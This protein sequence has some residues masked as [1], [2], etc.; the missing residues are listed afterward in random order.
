MRNPKTNN[1]SD[2]ARRLGRASAVQVYP[3]CRGHTVVGP[4]SVVHVA[5]V[6]ELW[7]QELWSPVVISDEDGLIRQ[8]SGQFESLTK[9]LWRAE[10]GDVECFDRSVCALRPISS[11]P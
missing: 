7:E 3:D 4:D 8:V 6:R 5:T 11:V 9:R 1:E 10:I 2:D